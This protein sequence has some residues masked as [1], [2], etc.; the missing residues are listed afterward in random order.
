MCIRDSSIPLSFFGGIGG[1]SA[2]GILVKGSTYLEELAD[3]RVV[4]FDKT[5]T[6][7]QGTFK[8]VKVCPVEGGTEDSLVEAAALAESWSKHPIS[9]SIKAAYGKDIDAAR[10][11]DVEELGGHGVTAKVDGKPVAAGNARLMAK[12]GLT[13]PDVPQTGT[14]VHVAIDGKYAG[15]LLISDVVKPHSA[16][17]IKGLKQAGVRKTVMLTGDA[18]PVAKAVSAELGIDEYHAIRWTRSRSSWPPRSPKRCWPSWVTAST[19]PLSSPV[20]MWA[21][22][23][24]LWALTPPLRPPTSS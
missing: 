8:V 6:L 15:Y 24:V 22:P 11:T 14:I 10:V 23:W 3:T 12:L 13:V 1:A 17:A 5:G 18:E 2:C 16:Q 20:W 7:T 21:S 4:V 9:L 19:T